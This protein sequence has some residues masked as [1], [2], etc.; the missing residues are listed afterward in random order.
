M[1]KHAEVTREEAPAGCHPE[2]RNYR[3]RSS[4][5]SACSL[6]SRGWYPGARC[7]EDAEMQEV[8]GRGEGVASRPKAG[9]ARAA[10]DPR[11]RPPA[12]QQCG[13][14]V[15]RGEAAHSRPSPAPKPGQARSQHLH[16]LRSRLEAPG[17]PSANNQIAATSLTAAAAPFRDSQPSAAPRTAKDA[18]PK[19][20]CFGGVLKE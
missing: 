2:P 10:S 4:S 18:S 8:P 9:R 11:T 7:A 16:S 19:H 1:E 14:R 20:H 3:A 13:S 15:P 6:A 5:R 17:Q 12:P